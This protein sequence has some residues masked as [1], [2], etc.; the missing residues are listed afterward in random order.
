[1]LVGAFGA[2]GA[3]LL[4]SFIVE[5]TEEKPV[6]KGTISTSNEPLLE[7][8]EGGTAENKIMATVEP[9]GP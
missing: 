5:P 3:C 7:T 4:I 6:G 2:I 8:E 9:L 1:M